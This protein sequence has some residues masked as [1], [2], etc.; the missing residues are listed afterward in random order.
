[1]CFMTCVPVYL[2]TVPYNLQNDLN[3]LCRIFRAMNRNAILRRVVDELI[4]IPVEMFDHVR[5]DGMRLLPAFAP[6]G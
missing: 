6:I 5:A 3:R 4:E 1:M 2:F